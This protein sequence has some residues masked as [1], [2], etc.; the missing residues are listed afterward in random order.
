MGVRGDR[1][2]EE[3][4]GQE[5][6]SLARQRDGG[7]KRERPREQRAQSFAHADVERGAH[8]VL[9]HQAR[10]RVRPLDDVRAQQVR[11][12]PGLEVLPLQLRL[13][14][15]RMA[16]LPQPHA[17]LDVLDRRLGIA[18]G[19]EAADAPERVGTNGAAP[20]PEGLR[21]ALGADVVVAMRE[22]LVLREEV[23]RCRELV[24][25]AEHRR[26]PG[27]R[28]RVPEHARRVGVHDDVR[29]DEPEDVAPGDLGAAVAGAARAEP[30]ARRHDA[31]SGLG[32]DPGR[33]VGRA[34]VDDD[35]LG[36]LAV[37]PERDERREAAREHRFAVVDG[38]DHA[39]RRRGGTS[40]APR[41][42]GIAHCLSPIARSA[43]RAAS[44]VRATGPS[45]RSRSAPRRR[46]WA[47]MR[48]SR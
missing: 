30:P 37:E 11:E 44:H 26:G 12:V 17:Q 21:R 36:D 27:P 42:R 22:V 14:P 7:G 2:D 46:K 34:V 19:V 24:V 25:G 20:G 32:R 9:L 1:R 16:P 15:D 8:P 47:S 35:H 13:D 41:G 4:E 40:R 48:G 23:R 29:V 39:D 5:E 28:E 43:P 31:R 38:D 18:F 45:M 6:R 3:R 10:P 33:R